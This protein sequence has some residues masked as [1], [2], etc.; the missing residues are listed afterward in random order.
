MFFGPGLYV[1]IL[2]S[3]GLT[4]FCAG[5]FGAS[6]FL[7]ET[8]FSNSVHVGAIAGITLAAMAGIVTMI[9]SLWRAFKPH[10]AEIDGVLIQERECPSLWKFVK[11]LASQV[12]VDPPTHLILGLQPNFYVT[13]AVLSYEIPV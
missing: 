13:E 11:E 6:I 3:I 10:L 8:A 1:A 2:V 4:L 7:A 5:L 12:H 9:D